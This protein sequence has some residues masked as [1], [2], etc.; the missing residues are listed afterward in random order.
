VNYAPNT[1][2]L[3]PDAP[4]SPLVPGSRTLRQNGYPINR[5][6]SFVMAVTFTEAGPRG[7]AILTYGESGDPASPHFAD[8]TEL[9]SRK[10]WREILFTDEQIRGD[11]SST[12]KV[13]TGPRQD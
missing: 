1:T 13:V 3:E 12:V 10:G 8:Q 11:R 2:T 9:F 6:S 5:G 4:V 7:R